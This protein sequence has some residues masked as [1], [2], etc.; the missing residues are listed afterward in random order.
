MK[1]VVG[2]IVR[3]NNEE[4]EKQPEAKT[5]PWRNAA[6]GQVVQAGEIVAGGNAGNQIVPFDVEIIR[7]RAYCTDK[8]VRHKYY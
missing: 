7:Y 3:E 5:L 6:V 8:R 2:H 1:R 4:H